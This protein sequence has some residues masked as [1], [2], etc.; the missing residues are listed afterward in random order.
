MATKKPAAPR[1][2]KVWDT[3]PGAKP[4]ARKINSW[5]F[6]RWNLWRGCPARYEFNVIKRL[7]DPQNDA[8]RRGIDVGERTAAYLTK[9]SNKIPK[10]IDPS[11]HEAYKF[12]RSQRSLFVEQEWGFRQNWEPVDYRDWDNC[13]LRIKVDVGYLD[14]KENVLHITDN[15]TGQWKADRAA[16]Y[17]EQ[18]SLYAAAAI[19]KFPRV[20]HVT[21]MLAYT[22]SGLVYPPG[23]KVYTAAEARE[24]QKE[25]SARGKK[26]LDAKSFKATPGNHCRWCPYSKSKGGPC[27]F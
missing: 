21:T 26:L 2:N 6:S 13:W 14:A 23:G 4:A 19:C 27:K 5:S 1:V 12:L 24:L 10:E 18:L 20:D 8:M 25:W 9:A 17:Q 3:K 11:L 16:E 15:K 22:D 7:P